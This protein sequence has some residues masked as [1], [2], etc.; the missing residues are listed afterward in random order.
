MFWPGSI[1][2]YTSE[3]ETNLYEEY[4]E[5]TGKVAHSRHAARSSVFWRWRTGS[6]APPG[7]PLIRVWGKSSP[8]RMLFHHCGWGSRK[9][10]GDA[11]SLL[12]ARPRPPVMDCSS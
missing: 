2:K 7:E 3:G 4:R 5:R 6:T 11:E 1:T 10:R 9:A 12:R 8:C